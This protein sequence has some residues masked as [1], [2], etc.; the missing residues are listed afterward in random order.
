M[1]L[2]IEEF[3]NF[4]RQ[5]DKLEYVIT[6]DD[7]K[8][9]ENILSEIPNR[10]YKNVLDIG[11]GT[12][13]ITR[14]L[15]GEKVHGVDISSKA[16]EQANLH[17]STRLKFS[18]AS[19]FELPSKLTDKYDLVVITELLYTPYIG[20]SHNLIYS[21]INQLILDDG[22]LLCCHINEWYEARFPYLMLEY[23]LFEYKNY[24]QRLEVYIK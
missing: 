17:Q 6:P 3:E 21:L 11:C 20:K 10:N 1:L 2:S 18:L 19:I 5:P 13:F 15:P 16:I 24:T 12:G 8:R 9:K 14:E 23:C 7:N 22:I 4:Y